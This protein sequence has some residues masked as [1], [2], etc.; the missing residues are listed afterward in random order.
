ML[1]NDLMTH[2]KRRE[3]MLPGRRWGAVIGRAE[4]SVVPLGMW[5]CED[6]FPEEGSW[7]FLEGIPSLTGATECTAWTPTGSRE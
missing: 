7:V 6:T 3:L 2:Q 1:C 5:V 4:S